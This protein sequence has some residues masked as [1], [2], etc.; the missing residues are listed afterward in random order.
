M[1]GV[2]VNVR[3]EAAQYFMGDFDD[4]G[5]ISHLPN[6]PLFWKARERSGWLVLIR[7]NCYSSKGS[8]GTTQQGLVLA[9]DHHR[10]PY[11]S[12]C[13]YRGAMDIKMDTCCLYLSGLRCG[14]CRYSRDFTTHREAH[15]G[16][17]KKR[18]SPASGSLKL[19]MVESIE[20]GYF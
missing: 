16:E 2:V 3:Q 8:M 6:L 13:H 18:L 20:C 4:V 9:N 14:W 11:S 1:Q 19:N 12:I 10:Q 5:D 17:V 7:R 15:I